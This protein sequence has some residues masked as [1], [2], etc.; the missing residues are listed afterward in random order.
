LFKRKIRAPGAAVPFRQREPATLRID[1]NA[2]AGERIVG[3]LESHAIGEIK[4]RAAPSTVVVVE[5]GGMDLAVHRQI[6]DV[7]NAVE[8]RPRMPGTIG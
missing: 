4:N 6:V 7:P 1:R 5:H 8:R 3:A 2:V